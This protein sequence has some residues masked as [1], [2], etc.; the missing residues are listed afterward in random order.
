M[1]RVLP[2][3]LSKNG[4]QLYGHLGK[5]KLQLPSSQFPVPSSHPNEKKRKTQL[6]SPKQ[7]FPKE[8]IR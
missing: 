3:P 4:C 6:I 2:I 8:R 1:V 5:N 7:R